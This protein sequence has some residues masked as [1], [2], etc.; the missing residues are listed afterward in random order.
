MSGGVLKVDGQERAQ[1]A[2]DAM[3]ATAGCNS[4]ADVLDCLRKAPYDA[5]YAAVQEQRM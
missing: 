3:A 1:P 5:L 4:T 2:F